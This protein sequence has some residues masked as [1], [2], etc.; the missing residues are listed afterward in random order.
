MR[1]RSPVL[2]AALAV[3]FTVGVVVLSASCARRDAGLSADAPCVV[4]VTLDNVRADR[5]GAYGVTN[6][7]TPV[8][9]GLARDGARFEDFQAVAPL[10]VPAHASLLTGLQP[11][12]HG[13]RV[14]GAGRL[15][16]VPTLA[17]VL[18]TA[19]YRTGA[20]VANAALAKERGFATGFERYDVGAAA[21]GGATSGTSRAA[22]RLR[23]RPFPERPD[24]GV[25]R[26]EE[27]T[28]AALG[29]LA[30]VTG[31]PRKPPTVRAAAARKVQD[32]NAQEPDESASKP[33]R[34]KRPFFLWLQ[35]ADPAF[36]DTPAHTQVGG[37]SVGAYDAEMAYTDLQIGR[38]LAFLGSHGLRERTLVVVVGA[39]G[40]EL[41]PDAGAD[42]GLVLSDAT[43]SVPAIY[44]WTGTIRA[45]TLVAATLNQTC[46]APTIA[47][48]AG[49]GEPFAPVATARS[50]AP[51]LLARETPAATAAEPAYVETLWPQHA[52]GLAPRRGWTTRSHRFVQGRGVVRRAAAAEGG[53]AD[54]TE[55]EAETTLARLEATFDTSRAAAAPPPLPEAAFALPEGWDREAFVTLWQNVACRLRHPSPADEALLTDCRRLAEGRPDSATFQTWV[56]IAHSL[57]KQ[58]AEAVVTQR[59]AL[60]L[61]PGTPHILSNLGLAYLDASDLPKAI[62][63]LEDAYLARPDDPEYRDNLAAVLMNTGVALARNK[64]FNDAMACMTRVLY[65]QPANPVAHVNMGSVY[66]GMGRDD[67]AASSYR[68]A[69]ELSPGFKPAQRAL[70]ALKEQ[71]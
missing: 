54:P 23:P 66:Q 31:A 27:V 67:L 38:V 21:S 9:D 55:Q 68:R 52:Y 12:E 26:G 28:E 35:L 37:R 29:W 48:L 1:P 39:H 61:A 46:V 16:D 30:D 65:L 57:R 51:L 11:P 5:I 20:F 33:L 13:L 40:L 4:L 41:G 7:F 14:P 17:T 22:V 69:L 18:R 2:S 58:V 70:D 64:A 63:K 15:A 19:G 36:R 25:R 43:L 62:D 59:R 8:L 24:A 6:A 42:P 32:A 10:S 45:G 60:E 44:A 47:E 56:G 50:V 53:P 49:C 71:R 34:L 3:G